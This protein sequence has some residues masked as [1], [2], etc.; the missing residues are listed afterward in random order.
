MYVVHG[1]PPALADEGEKLESTCALL[2]EYPRGPSHSHAKCKI[3][4]VVGDF[5]NT[6]VAGAILF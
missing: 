5:A 2:L 4:N 6:N 1:G 3:A